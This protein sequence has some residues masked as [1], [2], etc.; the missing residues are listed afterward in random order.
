M[1]RTHFP[2]EPAT[3][4]DLH[5][6][7]QEADSQHTPST[8]LPEAHEEAKAAVQPSPLP[9]AVTLYSHVSVEGPEPLLGA[10]PNTTTTPR[11]L[12]KTMLDPERCEGV[13][14]SARTYQVGAPDSTS[15][16]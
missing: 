2:S 13:L 1:A 16:V 8:Q 15:Q 3:S 6:P 9:K 4:H 14:G 10:P 5:G 11:P 12:S 7:V